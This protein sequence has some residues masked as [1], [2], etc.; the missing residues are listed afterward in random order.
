MKTIFAIIAAMA[1]NVV[2]GCMTARDTEIFDD[3]VSTLNTDAPSEQQNVG[4]KIKE[5]T[6]VSSK[7]DESEKG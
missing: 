4:E 6:D 1:L 2:S 5:P 7:N 3:F